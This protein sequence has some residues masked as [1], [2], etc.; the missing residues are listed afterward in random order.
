MLEGDDDMWEE[1]RVRHVCSLHSKTSLLTHILA[2]QNFMKCLMRMFASEDKGVF[3]YETIL[4]L[5]QQRHTVIECVPVP[6]NTFEDLPAYF[7]VSNCSFLVTYIADQGG[8][9]FVGI[10]PRIRVRM[11]AAPQGHRLQRAPRRFPS[12]YGT[13]PTILCRAMGL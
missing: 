8:P 13:Q 6:W 12:R 7:K 11:V 3:F 5:K 10:H 4:N 2:I 9:S 1:V